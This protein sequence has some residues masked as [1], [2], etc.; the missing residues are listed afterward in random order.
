MALYEGAYTAETLPEYRPKGYGVE[1]I[2]CR[3]YYQRY[4]K[5]DIYAIASSY[6]N[7][8]GVMFLPQQMRVPP[9]VTVARNGN[10]G[11][12]H[13][14]VGGAEPIYIDYSAPRTSNDYIVMRHKTNYVGASVEFYMDYIELSA[15]L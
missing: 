7:A 11:K 8:D 15:D 5:V 14:F 6:C 10:V 4:E 1:L 12:L 2:E 3:R 13:V 9:T